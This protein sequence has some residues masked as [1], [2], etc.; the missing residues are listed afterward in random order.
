MEARAVRKHIRSAPRKMRRV[1]NMV[2]GKNVAEALGLL[3]FT[4]NRAAEPVERTIQDAV[5]NLIDQ[6]RDERFDEGDLVIREIRVDGGPM[7]KR[8]RP[9]ARGRAHPYR[10]RTSHLTV[11]V[12]TPEDE[13]IDLE[14]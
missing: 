7:F 1:I 3:S 2:R 6:H 4:P 13:V 11:V 5:Y 12:G 14:S 9:A 8:F 10:K